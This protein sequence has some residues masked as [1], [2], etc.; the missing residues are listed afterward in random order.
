MGTDELRTQQRITGLIAGGE[1]IGTVLDEIC[2]AVEARCSGG[3]CCLATVDRSAGVMRFAAGP[4]TSVL[5]ETL[6][7]NQPIGR[8]GGASG[9][10]VARREWLV[11]LDIAGS[12]FNESYARTVLGAGIRALWVQPVLSRDGEVIA[13]I[14]VSQQVSRGP[15]ALERAWIEQLAVLAGLALELDSARLEFS[16]WI[17]HDRVTGL[18][19]QVS[20]FELVG[21]RLA[22]GDDG[23]S[24]MTVAF[25][26]LRLDGDVG[27]IASSQ[28]LRAAA[29]RIAAMV[30]GR[31]VAAHFA[32]GEFAV[33]VDRPGDACPLGDSLLGAFSEPVTFALGE[34]L[35]AP[36][37][38]I[39]RAEPGT[40]VRSLIS[41]A[42]VAMRDAGNGAQSQAAVYSEHL[43]ASVA[44]RV[45]LG[46]DL[47]RAIESNELTLF[48][49]PLIDLGGGGWHEVEALV[50]WHHP[51]RG[52]LLPGQFI[53]VA[54][55][56]GQ[57]VALGQ[58]VLKL[59]VAQARRWLEAGVKRRIAVNVS[60]QQLVD[61]R[62]ARGLEDLL[63]AVG[64]SSEV[65]MLE[66]TE[67]ELM[68]GLDSLMM[69]LLDL[70]AAGIDL[71]I[72]DFGTGHSSLSRLHEM[73][74]TAVKIDRSFVVRLGHGPQAE[75]VIRAIADIAAS[76]GCRV[77]AEGVEDHDAAVAVRRAGCGYAQGFY[78]GRPVPAGAL[79]G[80][81]PALAA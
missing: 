23:F 38:G 18:L 35:L 20:F 78:F 45:N 47:R 26:R 22:S 32:A 44:R 11:Y 48:Y 6:C 37:I 50:R 60:P 28:V 21:R 3:T 59:A 27:H 69:T 41:D 66:I 72:D 16:Q 63:A 77:V 15:S 75:T 67:T 76:H 39:A 56:S 2:L 33:L 4:S 53:D 29:Q 49:Q 54:E 43:R 17:R 24:V 40:D 31:G 14:S 62:F 61:P 51:K 80:G 52:L 36:K 73:P 57:I 5:I 71:L 58:Q 8:D 13:A 25:D 1:S 74:I 9:A 12:G 70:R 81:R 7:E 55:E 68:K 34:L 65:I 42:E 79:D 30:A 46:A 64:L 10:S 19:N